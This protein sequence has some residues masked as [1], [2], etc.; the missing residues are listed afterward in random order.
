MLLG[1]TGSSKF[2]ISSLDVMF[3]VYDS[4]IGPDISSIKLPRYLAELRIPFGSDVI[5][6]PAMSAMKPPM[7]SM[8][9]QQVAA[10][11]HTLGLSLRRFSS[12]LGKVKVTLTPSLHPGRLQLRACTVK[13]SIAK[14]TSAW[15][16]NRREPGAVMVRESTGS[17]NSMVNWP[18]SRSNSAKPFS[19][20]RGGV[21][22]RKT[23]FA[24]RAF[25]TLIGRSSALVAAS[26]MPFPESTTS[27]VLAG[28]MPRNRFSFRMFRSDSTRNILTPVR[29]TASGVPQALNWSSAR[30]TPLESHHALRVL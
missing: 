11:V 28:L 20:T 25:A 13:E 3:R 22:S 23:L 2:R 26:R 7:V 16:W 8:V 14:V 18:A 19:P 9:S 15:C 5:W 24:R 21:V 30:F 4:R 29:P 27:L 12:A 17:S 10:E 6:L 1:S